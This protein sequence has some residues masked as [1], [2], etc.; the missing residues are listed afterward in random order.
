MVINAGGHTS[1]ELRL[2]DANDPD[3]EP[4]LISAREDGLEYYL[5]EARDRFYFRT[6]VD[7]AVDFKIVS[8]PLDAPGR[9]NWEDFVPHRPGTL[10]MR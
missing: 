5:T 7:G 2:L 9:E 4:V 3:A 8:A 1:N 10:S 6:N